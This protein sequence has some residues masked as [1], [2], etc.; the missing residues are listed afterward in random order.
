MKAATLN[1]HD[2]WTLRGVGIAK[3]RFPMIL[4]CDAAGIDLS[5]GREVVVYGV[6]P[7][8]GWAGDETLDPGRSVLSEV[9]QGT[10]AEY[11]TVPVGN[12]VDK[13]PHISFE[14]GAS[15]GV[16]WL[17]AYRMLF[18]NADLRPGNTVLVQGASG[19]VAS[20][21][22]ALARAAG[23]QVWATARTEEKRAFAMQIGAHE[24]FP[25][26]ARLPD[27]VDAV[28]ETV[29]EATWSH[30]LKAT[31]PGGRI[32]ISGATTGDMP[33][34]ELKRVFFLQLHV[35]GSTM[36]TRQ[37]LVDVLNFAS[38]TGLRPHIDRVV[39][40]DDAPEAFRAMD[41]G[42]LLGKAVFLP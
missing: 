25:S 27:R 23:L 28:M 12:V 36:G 1:H 10:I 11:V 32:V 8:P 3:E 24:A 4:G 29:G 2:I 5:T 26:G 31:R 39:P 41:A 42:E 34:A 38:A 21:C 13:P 19:G 20:A 30:S 33:P 22:I 40:F 35:V 18:R 15:I 17:T 9:H 6:V 16:A 37:E 7:S 14:D